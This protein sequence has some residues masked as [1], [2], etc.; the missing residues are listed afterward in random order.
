MEHIVNIAFHFLR[1]FGVA[2]V[3]LSMFIENIGIPL[4]TELGYLLGQEYINSQKYSFLF[5]LFILTLGHTT[6]AIISYKIGS[7]SDS[8]VNERLQKNKKIIEVH[9][10]LTEWYK[11]FGNATVFLTRF[12]GYVRP[13]SSFVAGFA[14]VKFWPFVFWTALGSL[15]FN[16]IVL[17]LSSVLMLIWRRYSAYHLSIAI[18]MFLLFFAII[19]YELF[20]IIFSVRKNKRKA[21]R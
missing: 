15:I 2:G 3:F 12:V 10:K 7:W 16:I 6:G 20:K 11:K 13:W 17:Y 19:I 1:S 4:P 9:K 21:E 5:I 8:Y 18:G 14:E